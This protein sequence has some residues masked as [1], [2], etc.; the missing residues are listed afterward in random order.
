MLFFLWAALVV[1][2]YYVVHKPF[3]LPLLL[4]LWPLAAVAGALA[5]G[6]GLGTMVVRGDEG[7][8]RATL[9]LRVG[10]GLGLL[11]IIQLALAAV[12]ALSPFISWGAWIIAVGYLVATGRRREWAAA[13]RWPGDTASRWLALFCGLALGG[14]L[15][16]ALAPPTAWDA[17]VYHLTVPKLYL[18]TGRLTGAVDLPY[19]G[20]PQWGEMLFLWLLPVGGDRAAAVLHWTFAPLTL[21]LV[22]ELL[23]P[24]A[25]GRGWLAAA[26]VLSTGTATLLAGW[27]YVEWMMM[28]AVTA[29]CVCLT[30]SFTAEAAE[31]AEKEKKFLANSAR[32]AVSFRWLALAGAFAGLAFAAKYTAAGA[33][34][35]LAVAV[36][37]LGGGTLTQRAQRLTVFG[38][39]AVVFVL[40]WL[41]KDWALTGNPVYPFFFGGR[42]WDSWRAAW[43]ARGGTGLP[44][45]RLLIAPWEM[46][47]QG[48]EGAPGY[49]ATLGPLWLALLP[50]VLIGWRG[51]SDVARKQLTLL[52]TVIGVAFAAWLA[53]AAWSAQLQ[54]SRLLFGVFPAL[55]C[56]LASGLASGFPA[57]E[58]NGVNFRWVMNALI[59]L[60]LALASV[61]Y[62]V[63]ALAH[64]PLSVLTGEQS[65]ADYLRQRLG[66]YAVAMEQVNVLPPG[67]KVV[68][69]WEPRTYPCATVSRCEGDTLLDRWWH[70]RRLG[71]SAG[72]AAAQWRAE[73]A[74]HVLI[75]EL[76]R[77]T[78]EAQG[79][80]PFTPADWAELKTLIA[81]HLTSMADFG[82]AYELYEIK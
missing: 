8:S 82:G 21:L 30:R 38:A 37:A 10:M 56:V 18:Q 79:F 25:P 58:R 3:A 32:S 74:T 48:A 39:G 24:I 29:A 69:L 22:P 13:W 49:A 81:E 19:L 43:Y 1:V 33:A 73:G 45:W 55:A 51:R 31:S 54:Q 80:D 72:A 44:P 46:T 50:A 64:N 66:W 75:F 35:G 57:P 62:A 12:G 4:G 53:Q 76:G 11:A 2:A 52:L 6:L 65:E 28:F 27:P 7:D 16:Q 23:R 77:A 63:E 67:S 15:L 59:A 70:A 40:P 5:A 68:F 60:V 17:L 61:Q 14:A 78:I 34:I 41:I 26:I 36:A 71:Q 9:A 20:F 47:V 42:F